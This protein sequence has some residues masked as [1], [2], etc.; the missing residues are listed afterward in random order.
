VIFVPLF[1][2]GFIRITNSLY[3]SCESSFSAVVCILICNDIFLTQ[4][5]YNSSKVQS[6]FCTKFGVFSGG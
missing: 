3:S 6:K 2:P 5:E 4:P 1:Q